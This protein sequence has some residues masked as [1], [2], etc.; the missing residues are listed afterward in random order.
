MA[1]LRVWMDCRNKA[2]HGL[3]PA[4]MRT[5]HDFRSCDECI[6]NDGG[7]VGVLM[8]TEGILVR[9]GN[10]TALVILD[11][12]EAFSAAFAVSPVRRSISLVVQARWI[13]W[14]NGVG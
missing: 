9:C 2:T 7:G 3:R 10:G 6:C 4:M 14:E 8:T 5:S 12:N 13:L 11:L 1:I